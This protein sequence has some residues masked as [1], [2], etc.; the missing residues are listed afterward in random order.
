MAK[1]STL[2]KIVFFSLLLVGFIVIQYNWVQSLQKD[3]EQEF[4]AR[5]ISGINK[6]GVNIHNSRSLHKLTDPTIVNKLRRSLAANG[7]GNIHFEFS[8]SSGDNHL[9]SRGFHQKLTGNS[10]NLTFYYLF[11]RNSE[12]STSDVALTV[13]IPF[14]KK[15]VFK[16]M[17]WIIAASLLLT[18]MMLAIF[19]FTFILGERRQQ[20]FYDNR[21]NAI[22]NMMKHLE[23]PLST[24]SVATEALR[25]DRVMHD[26]R[27]MNYYQQIIN[28]ESKRMNEQVK[29]L[30]RDLE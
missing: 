13:V 11:P 27:K 29:K 8:I 14:W 22:R 21:T 2:I 1:R 12:K 9:T 16:E 10:N 18:I 5:I 23:T 28:E 24:V 20:L 4:S 17:A 19:C 6:V 25:N 30:L 26:S 7:M 3:K 15:Y